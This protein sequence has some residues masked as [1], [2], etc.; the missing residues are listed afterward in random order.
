MWIRVR[1]PMPA[2]CWA[3][4]AS[5]PSA[6]AR[7]GRGAL[8]NNSLS[9]SMAMMSACLVTAQNGRYVRRP[10]RIPSTQAT[11]SLARSQASESCNQASSAYPLG[12][13]STRALSLGLRSVGTVIGTPPLGYLTGVR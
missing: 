6:G 4:I 12:F 8:I 11:G 10:W 13:A 7:S 5:S 3:F 2:S 1:S 9:R